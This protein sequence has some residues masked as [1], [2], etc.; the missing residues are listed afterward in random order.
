[1]TIKKTNTKKTDKF[2]KKNGYKFDRYSSNAHGV[3]KHESFNC[4]VNVSYKSKSNKMQQSNIKVNVEKNKH[5]LY[6]EF[7][8]IV[9]D[10]CIMAENNKEV[11]RL[12]T[13]IKDFN[14]IKDVDGSYTGIKNQ[15]YR[16][17]SNITFKERG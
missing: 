3:Y 8:N 2:L 16:F 17:C 4:S 15:W 13:N 14:L 10:A 9:N 5:K 11:D 1:M 7:L 12:Q 6:E